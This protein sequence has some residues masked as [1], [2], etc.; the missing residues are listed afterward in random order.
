MAGEGNTL[1]KAKPA[2]AG[3][4][5]ALDKLA[6]GEGTIIAAGVPEGYEAFLLAAMARRLPVD[7][8]VPA[9][10]AAHRPRQRAAGRG[11]QSA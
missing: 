11:A 4:P 5:S 6:G 7:T 8:A 1:G 3:A 10:R 2:P 9:G